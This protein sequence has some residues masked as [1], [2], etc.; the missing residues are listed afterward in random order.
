MV[1]LSD[2][3]VVCQVLQLV[4]QLLE[5]EEGVVWHSITAVH[6]AAAVIWGYRSARSAEP[7]RLVASD[8]PG[9]S[10]NMLN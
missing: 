9:R 10:R 2:D 8:W 7:C 6:D 4:D 1:V 3:E 5:V